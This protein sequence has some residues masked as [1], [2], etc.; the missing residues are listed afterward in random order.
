M[1]ENLDQIAARTLAHYDQ[2]ALAY[3]CGKVRAITT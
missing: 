1:P 2:R 3:W